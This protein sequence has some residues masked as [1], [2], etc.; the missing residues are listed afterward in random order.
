[1]AECRDFFDNSI[2]VLCRSSAPCKETPSSN[3]P[4]GK[5]DESS[6]CLELTLG[7]SNFSGFTAS[8]PRLQHDMVRPGPAFSF[9]L[10]QT[11]GDFTSCVP[12][13]SYT[14]QSP[15]LQTDGPKVSNGLDGV[16]AALGR[17]RSGNFGCTGEH[18][19]FPFRGIADAMPQVKALLPDSNSSFPSRDQIWQ[20][21]QKRGTLFEPKP[22]SNDVSSMWSRR[23]ASMQAVYPRNAGDDLEHCQI[24]RSCSNGVLIHTLKHEVSNVESSLEHSPQQSIVSV[25]H[26]HPEEFEELQKRKEMQAQRRLEARKRRRNLIGEKQHKRGKQNSGILHVGSRRSIS[27]NHKLFHGGVPSGDDEA[28]LESHCMSLDASKFGRLDDSKQQDSKCDMQLS[29]IEDNE[30]LSQDKKMMSLLSNE[31]DSGSHGSM[32]SSELEQPGPMSK[33]TMARGMLV[34]SNEH[35]CCNPLAVTTMTDHVRMP[36]SEK[37]GAKS[38]PGCETECVENT[39]AP[40]DAAKGEGGMRRASLPSGSA[41]CPPLLFSPLQYAHATAGN[42]GNGSAMQNLSTVHVSCPPPI[43]TLAGTFPLSSGTLLARTTSAPKD[44]DSEG[45]RGSG[46]KSAFSPIQRTASS[47]KIVF[48]ESQFSGA[49]LDL[50][51]IGESVVVAKLLC[52]GSSLLMLKGEGAKQEEASSESQLASENSGA[53]ALYAQSTVIEKQRSGSFLDFPWVTTTG[54]GPNGITVNGYMY[55]AN[56]RQV[57]LVCNCHG[58]H[59]SP[60]EFVEHSGSSDLSNPERN[61]VVSPS[62]HFNHQVASTPV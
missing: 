24:R 30:R 39:G 28:A 12:A 15:L 61:I 46:D 48:G 50:Q 25:A 17:Q 52:G 41:G 35:E 43:N 1:M 56:G 13:T 19:L 27:P 20:T 47:L 44:E 8:P 34:S 36:I 9:L 10:R 23:A 40:A 29:S 16:A 18:P 22:L 2:A 7:P 11:S 49:H 58:K 33:C 38:F 51:A 26:P 54:K 21:L 42:C 60:V 55:L 3:L 62:P 32:T 31:H 4:Q 37:D 6:H 59:M 5:G 45:K 14:S 57:R 53:D